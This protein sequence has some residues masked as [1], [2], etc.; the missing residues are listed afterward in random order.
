MKKIITTMTLAAAPFILAVCSSVAVIAGNSEAVEKTGQL[1]AEI[2]VDPV[3]AVV[4]A[5]VAAAIGV[6]AFA[7]RNWFGRNKAVHNEDR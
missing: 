4:C 3:R 6:L 5:G 2:S 7:K 1:A